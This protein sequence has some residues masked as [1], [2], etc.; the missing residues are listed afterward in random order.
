[1]SGTRHDVIRTQR[2]CT[3]THRADAALEHLA[4][5]RRDARGGWRRA[6]EILAV[7]GVTAHVIRW[8]ARWPASRR[9][10]TVLAKVELVR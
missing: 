8:R 6:G 2:L 9:S 4:L 5:R 10:S 7:V 1:M 3:G